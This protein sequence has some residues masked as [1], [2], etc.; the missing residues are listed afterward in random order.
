LLEE[1]NIQVGDGSPVGELGPG[2]YT[3]NIQ[4]TSTISTYDL[5]FNVIPEPSMTSLL[6]LSALCLMLRR[7]R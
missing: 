3:F 5:Q 2:T 7:H 1:S 6:G 4:N